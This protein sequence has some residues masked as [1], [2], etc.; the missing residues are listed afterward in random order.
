MSERT[1]EYFYKLSDLEAEKKEIEERIKALKALYEDVRMPSAGIYEDDFIKLRV[2]NVKKKGTFNVDALKLD[3]PEIDLTK[4]YNPDV[5][6]T[7]ASV[8]KK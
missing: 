5:E 1:L 2:T 4:Y 8:K 3:Y 6:Y 7:Y